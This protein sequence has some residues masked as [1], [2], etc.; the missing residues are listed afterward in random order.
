MVNII[1]REPD[2]PLFM[3][4]LGKPVFYRHFLK[5]IKE[6]IGLIGLDPDKFSTHSFRRGMATHAFRLGLPSDVIQLIGVQ[7]LISLI[8]N[9]QY[10][11]KL[12]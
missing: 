5:V 4:G 7:M 6:K 3:M 11:I 8:C 2:T 10:M 9:I 1:E 12:R